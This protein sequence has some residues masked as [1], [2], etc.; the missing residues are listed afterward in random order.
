MAWVAF[1]RMVKAVERFGVD[2]PVERWRGLR[3]TIHDE[4]CRKGFDAWRNTFV[5]YYG[6]TELDASLLMMPLVGFL[7]ARDPRISGTVAAI[8]RELMV[9]GFVQRYRTDPH[10][11]ALPPGEAAFLVCSFWLADNYAM[12]GRDDDARRLFE[13]LVG[14][15]NDVG[16]LSEGYDPGLKRLLG[17]FPQALSHLALVNTASNL[18]RLHG[19]AADRQSS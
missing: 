17:N 10:L 7:P 12:L 8:E 14:L 18:S 11:D 1:D 6:A 4:I 16:L 3:S 2:G 19:P 15:C 13:R 9:G 5:Q